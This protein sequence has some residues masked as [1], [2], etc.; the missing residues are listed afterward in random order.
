[1]PEKFRIE[2]I[3][4][5]LNHPQ[6]VA[7]APDGRIFFV[8]RTTGNIRVIQYGKLLP[9]PFATLVVHTGTEEGV[10]G[11]A[12]HPEFQTN[13][14]VY[15]YYSSDSPRTQRIVRFTA[16]GNLGT[17]MTVILDNIG[18][19][20]SGLDNGGALVFG[21]DAKLYAGVGVLDSDPSAQSWTSLRGKVLRMNDDGTVPGD[22]PH[23][24]YA[25]PYSSIL[26]IGF[27]DVLDLAVHPSVGTLYGT[28]IYD[29]EAACDEVNIPRSGLNYGW[30]VASCSTGA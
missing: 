28:D 6:A 20:T 9:T 16:A 4:R 17:N 5:S 23:P 12:L 2:P 30:N 10:L 13:G 26:A 22:N 27:R 1:M 3:A 25:Y 19:A 11:L 8:E 14:W 18:E 15:V 24:E 21:A 29:G 7:L